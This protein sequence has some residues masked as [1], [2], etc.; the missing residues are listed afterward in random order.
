MGSAQANNPRAR[1]V[2]AHG[3]ALGG[4]GM[5]LFRSLAP[6]GLLVGHHLLVGSDRRVPFR[7]LLRS[8]ICTARRC[9][10]HGLEALP[11]FSDLQTKLL[12]T[13][14][15]VA[16]CGEWHEHGLLSRH[17]PFRPKAL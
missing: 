12:L 1:R 11:Q 3:E 2:R 17:H 14:R 10:V 6:P 8:S 15:D 16:P 13:G 4:T 9:C 7:F 5:T